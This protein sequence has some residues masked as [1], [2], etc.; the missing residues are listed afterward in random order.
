MMFFSWLSLF[1]CFSRSDQHVVVLL[2][3]SARVSLVAGD[4]ARRL[5]GPPSRLRLLFREVSAPASR[6]FSNPRLLV[7]TRLGFENSVLVA[8]TTSPSAGES[9]PCT[10]PAPAA[11][12]RTE[13]ERGLREA[14]ESGF[15]LRALPRASRPRRFPPDFL[16][17][18]SLKVLEFRMLTLNI[19][20]SI[21]ELVFL[22][23]LRFGLRLI[24]GPGVGAQW[25]L[26]PALKPPC[27]HT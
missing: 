5:R 20:L 10:R 1:Y 19:F 21:F 27:F 22:W 25:L 6:P 7:F 8:G 2:V 15:R 14:G 23:A 24:W 3:A 9:G 13:T 12:V 16:R 11:P 17:G 4:G 18:R 26:D